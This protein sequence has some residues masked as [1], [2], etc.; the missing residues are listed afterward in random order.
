MGTRGLYGFRKD[1]MDKTTYNHCDSYPDCL[2]AA[3]LGFCAGTSNEEMRS[4]FDRI[5][6]VNEADK[7]TPEQIEACKD[8]VDLTVS[9]QSEHDWYCL[10]RNLQGEP[11]KWK[12]IKGPIFMID[13]HD[14]IKDS[15][16]CEYAYIIDLDEEVLEY[17][18]GFQ[19]KPDPLNPYG[20]EKDED[21]YFPCKK[22]F[23]FSLEELRCT[24]DVE[25]CVARMEDAEAIEQVLL[26]LSEALRDIYKEMGI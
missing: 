14:F 4:I 8:Y 20:D 25:G 17:W 7:P 15:L 16:F 22:L 2:G 3:M 21:G 9:T 23:E 26:D 6:L 24:K 10:L 11:E 12:Q 13:N 19:R 5:I 1:G 18:I